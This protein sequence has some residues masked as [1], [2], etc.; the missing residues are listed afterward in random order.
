MAD[1][2]AQARAV[3]QEGDCGH[4]ALFAVRGATA[5]DTVDVSAYFKVVKRAGM[6]SDTGTTIATVTFTGT[7][8]TIPAGPTADGVWLIVVGVAA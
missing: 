3:Y 6:V 2:S 1:V 7:V 8:L 4:T 5:G